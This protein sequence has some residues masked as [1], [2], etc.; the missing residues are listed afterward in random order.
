MSRIRSK[1]TFIEVSLRKA[2]WRAGIRY[3]K[4]YKKLP[5]SP[6]I[7]ITKHK[8]AI[9]CDGEFW[10]GKDWENKTVTI[11]SNCAFWIKK[12][13]R[14]IERDNEVNRSLYGKGW[15]VIRFWGND[16]LNDLEGC[17]EDV[18]NV[19]FQSIISKYGEDFYVCDDEDHFN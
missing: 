2:L 10:H 7:A 17:V 12:I 11:R 3:R 15:T 18:Q 8:I 5:G 19:I 6:D 9:F 13:V 16:I 1:D 4:N 14:N